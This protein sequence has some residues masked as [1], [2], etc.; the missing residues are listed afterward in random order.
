MISIELGDDVME[1][2]FNDAA[3]EREI[4]ERIMVACKASEFATARGIRMDCPKTFWGLAKS[5]AE[6]QH[7]TSPVGIFGIFVVERRGK[8]VESREMWENSG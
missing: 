3:N 5:W 4:A 1:L 2:D 7:K 8:T 6:F